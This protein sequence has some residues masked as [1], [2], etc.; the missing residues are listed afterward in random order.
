MANKLNI[1]LVLCR[2]YDDETKTIS[3]I[4]NKITTN[5]KHEAT[6]S[7][8]TFVNGIS[9][10]RKDERFVLHYFLVKMEDD[11][12]DGM[13]LYIGNWIKLFQIF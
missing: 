1:N 11:T 5:N 2:K 12:G 13:T 7:I 9:D 8:V 3:S 10:T 4:F 6:F